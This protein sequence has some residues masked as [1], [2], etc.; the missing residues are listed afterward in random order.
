[1]NLPLDAKQREDL[2]EFLNA[3]FQE[4]NLEDHGQLALLADLS[5]GYVKD[6][7]DENV[8]V[9]SEEVFCKIRSALVGRVSKEQKAAVRE[10]M[11]EILFQDRTLNEKQ[12]E[13]LAEFLPEEPEQLYVTALKSDSPKE[14]LD[15]IKNKELDEISRGFLFRLSQVVGYNL[16]MKFSQLEN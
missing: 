4:D 2:A 7:L 5:V 13:L 10:K 11:D 14:K 15:K 9:I 16:E 6:L 3:H 1:M 8:K 12:R